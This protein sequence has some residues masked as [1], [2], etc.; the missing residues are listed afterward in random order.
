M[1]VRYGES[2]SA[3]AAHIH[4]LSCLLNAYCSDISSLVE[5]GSYNVDVVIARGSNF[6]FQDINAPRYGIIP[7]RRVTSS[8][9]DHTKTC[10][11]ASHLAAGPVFFQ[12]FYFWRRLEMPMW[13]IA[14]LLLILDFHAGSQLGTKTP[15]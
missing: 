13:N 11:Y 10:T 6:D 5:P 8:S 3:S 9:L 4:L 7:L 14:C 2:A 12:I 1:T 15:L